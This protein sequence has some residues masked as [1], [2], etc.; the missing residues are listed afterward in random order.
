MTQP[1]T[2][3]TT[4]ERSAGSVDARELLDELLAIGARR[5]DDTL[6]GLVLD[7]TQDVIAKHRELVEA[8]IK[9]TYPEDW[10]V[11]PS[12]DG[13][14]LCYLQDVGCQR[15]RALW[16]ISFDRTDLMRDMIEERIEDD[17]D[18]HFQYIAR[19][20]GTCSVTGE[21]SDE[22]GSRLTSDGLFKKAWVDARN[23]PSE[24]ARLRANVRKAALANG[25]GRLVR[26]FTGT[27][28]MPIEVLA[29]YGMDTAR[30]RGIKFESGT[31]GGSG[32]GASEPQ[33]KR[34]AGVACMEGKVAGF[35]KAN[36][37][38]VM[39][40][41]S[42]AQL[43]KKKASD[44]ID[45]LSKSESPVEPAKFW[46]GVGIPDPVTPKAVA[47]PPAQKSEP[48]AEPPPQ[49][50]EAPQWDPKTQPC[51]AC[52]RAPFVLE[53]DGHA[54]ACPYTPGAA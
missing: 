18:V 15:I 19:V 49:K 9:L 6:A 47:G 28:L 41:L 16:G 33:L 13:H 21:S 7:K 29:K 36:F 52:G 2:R 34:L 3:T 24:R 23:E 37:S 5:E 30:C 45:R 4:L 25:Q 12:R 35:T 22:L 8:S 51:P 11:Y 17:D 26:K 32:D 31:Q 42:G 50:D 53:K 44:L 27:N 20:G 39:Q 1:A 48:A 43:G 14:K 38:T 10:V 46:A 54:H 40:L